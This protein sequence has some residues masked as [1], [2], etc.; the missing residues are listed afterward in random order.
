MLLERGDSAVVARSSLI[1][2]AF[3]RTAPPCPESSMMG[4]CK[5]DVRNGP[6]RK[7]KGRRKERGGGK[8]RK[9]ISERLAQEHGDAASVRT[10]RCRWP[11][12]TNRADQTCRG[13]RV[14]T[15]NLI[16]KGRYHSRACICHKR[17]ECARLA[18]AA[19]GHLLRP[20]GFHQLYTPQETGPWTKTCVLVII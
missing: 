14:V 6:L 16:K 15:R 18:L 9:I 11:S 12:M 4:S 20:T 10:E 3:E 2:R 17:R 13:E 8:E 7:V 19:T 1:L 5:L